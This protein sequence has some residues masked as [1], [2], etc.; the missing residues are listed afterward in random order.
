MQKGLIQQKKNL[1]INFATGG[2]LLKPAVIDSK[3]QNVHC[4]LLE[5]IPHKAKANSK[6]HW[7]V[8]NH[9]KLHP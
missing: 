5:P 6:Q 3:S 9:I 8:T 1:H 7:M 4:S 2:R